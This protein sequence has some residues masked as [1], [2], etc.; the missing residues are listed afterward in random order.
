VTAATAVLSS[1]ALKRHPR[2]LAQVTQPS[3]EQ[4]LLTHD[5]VGLSQ[6]AVSD[7]D[8]LLESGAVTALGAALEEPDHRT[9][10]TV[11]PKS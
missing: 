3:P 11:V 7:S 4:R 9:T 6:F 8:A 5:K 10:L 1:A 2:T